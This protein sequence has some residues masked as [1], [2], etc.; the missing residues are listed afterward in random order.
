M[1]PTLAPQTALRFR[2]GSLAAEPTSN[3]SPYR[4]AT[5]TTSSSDAPVD[6]AWMYRA[7]PPPTARGY[8]STTAMGRAPSRG[9]LCNSLRQRRYAQQAPGKGKSGPCWGPRQERRALGP[10]NTVHLRNSGMQMT[11]QVPPSAWA[12]DASPARDR[13]WAEPAVGADLA[14]QWRV[15]VR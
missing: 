9:N 12:E 4:W 14:R 6:A 2:S 13:R 11:E 15:G 8:S 7:L 1:P 3:G 5:A 10:H